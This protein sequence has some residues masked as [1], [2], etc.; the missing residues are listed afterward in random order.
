MSEYRSTPLF[1]RPGPTLRGVEQDA[2]LLCQ[3]PCPSIDG[4]QRSTATTGDSGWQ[5]KIA[6]SGQPGTAKL[7][8]ALDPAMR[9]SWLPCKPGTRRRSRPWWTRGDR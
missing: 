5:H 8:E 6:R 4:E 7:H 3:F 1:A 2:G 9:R